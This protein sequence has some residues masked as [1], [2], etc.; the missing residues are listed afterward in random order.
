M[1]STDKPVPSVFLS[2]FKL[3]CKT[4][5]KNIIL[6]FQI[7]GN[8]VGRVGRCLLF[9]RMICNASAGSL[10]LES[11]FFRHNFFIAE[12]DALLQVHRGTNCTHSWI[13]NGLSKYNNEIVKLLLPVY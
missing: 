11:S 8:I 5:G 2:C 13:W 4:M 12:T 7:T 1:N 9:S 10:T 3:Q 6:K